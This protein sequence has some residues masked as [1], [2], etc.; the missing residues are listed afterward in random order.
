MKRW[1]LREQP[2]EKHD[3]RLWQTFRNIDLQTTIKQHE[4][5]PAAKLAVTPHLPPNTIVAVVNPSE[6]SSASIWFVEICQENLRFLLL[7]LCSLSADDDIILFAPN[8]NDSDKKP[9]TGKA[10]D[11]KGFLTSNMYETPRRVRKS[12]WKSIEDHERLTFS[13]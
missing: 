1:L 7:S 3:L 12:T 4:E 10:E 2:E 11:M 6:T 5:N 8:E 9:F 13:V